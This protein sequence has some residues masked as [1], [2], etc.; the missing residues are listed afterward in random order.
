VALAKD[1][2]KNGFVL[3]EPD[4][5]CGKHQYDK[6]FDSPPYMTTERRHLKLLIGEYV[7]TSMLLVIERKRS[8]WG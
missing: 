6:E 4:F 1:L 3:A 7:S 2:K 5:D 8:G